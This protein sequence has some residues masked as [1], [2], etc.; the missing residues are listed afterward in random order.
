MDSLTVFPQPLRYP[1]FRHPLFIE[2][3]GNP[4]TYME[5]TEFLF[6]SD[7]LVAPVVHRGCEAREV[8]LPAGTWYDFCTGRAHSGPGTITMEAPLEVLPLLARGGSVIPMREVTQYVGERPVDPLILEVFPSPDGCAQ[9]L[10][11]QDAGDGYGY[12]DE[13]YRVTAFEL[14]P[15]MQG[16]LFIQTPRE[17]NFQPPARSLL[18]KLHGRDSAP[19]GV[20]VGAEALPE[21]ASVQALLAT[22]RGWA[23]EPGSTTLW[24]RLGPQE[25]GGDVEVKIFLSQD[26]STLY[27]S[28][29]GLQRKTPDE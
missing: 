29:S 9:G 2:F 24:I 3:P 18:V 4:G 11:Y 27:A 5:E 12:E 25:S 10:L 16:L 7:L 20:S 17:G 15:W 22:G 21:R 28:E 26:P 19:A 13:E 8:Y 1:A 23:H 6:G 14:A